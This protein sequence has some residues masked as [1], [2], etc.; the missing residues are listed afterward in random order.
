[1]SPAES[2]RR[3]FLVR[4]G[5]FGVLAGAAAVVPVA[6]NAGPLGARTLPNPVLDLIRQ[7]LD[8]V[9]RDTYNG[10]AVFA[11]P[12]P[13]A[14]ST[15]QGTP[16]EE[17]G[18]LE[19][20]TADFMLHALDHFVP[21]P[22]Q[23]VR[24]IATALANGLTGVPLALPGGLP[25]VDTST[26][27]SLGAAA[28]ALLANDEELP[29]ALVVTL[30]LN[31]LALQVNPAAKSGKFTSPFARLSYAEKAKAFSLLE[32]ADTELVAAVDGEVPEP[33]RGSVSGIGKYLGGSLIGFSTFGAYCEW[34]TFQPEQRSVGSEP[35]GWRNSGYDPGVLDGWDDLQGYYQNREKVGA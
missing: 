11:V 12:G 32:G 22:D 25:G 18:A 7:A 35:V 23:L 31:F 4:L 5:L 34:A 30:L 8:E 28:D 29:L 15:Q 26:V 20:R 13:D 19:A 3:T 9:S 27:D 6:A 2:D 33:L 10:L 24:P 16:R 17:D 21:F 14:Y 1:M